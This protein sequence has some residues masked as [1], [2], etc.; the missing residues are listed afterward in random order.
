MLHFDCIS[1]AIM[2]VIYIKALNW[3]LSRTKAGAARRE[4]EVDGQKAYKSDNMFSLS[5]EGGRE[6]EARGSSSSS[7]SHSVGELIVVCVCP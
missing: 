1:Q 4:T 6:G 2:H 7:S 5:G 3:L